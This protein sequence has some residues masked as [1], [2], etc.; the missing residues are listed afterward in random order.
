MPYLKIDLSD[1][2]G[3][4]VESPVEEEEVIDDPVELADIEEEKKEI[5]A[6][7]FRRQRW[8]AYVKYVD[9]LVTRIHPHNL[10]V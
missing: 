4:D 8:P 3:E 10:I 6:E 9:S 1:C 5:E 2:T 7:V